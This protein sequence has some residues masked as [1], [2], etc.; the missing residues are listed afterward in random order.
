MFTVTIQNINDILRDYRIT[1][2]CIKIVELQRYYYEKDNLESKEVRLIVKAVLD[3][4]KELVIRFKN[5]QDVTFDLIE[6]Q[7][8]FAK[9]L[10]EN[11]I[12]TPAIYTSEGH[13]ARIYDF[14]GYEV[15]VTVEDFVNGELKE[16]DTDIAR[17]AGELLARMHNISE[18]ADYHISN[19]ILFDPL[20]QNEL[21]S[22][23]TFIENEC[24][25]RTID[26]DL[27]E[28]ILR[29]LN[30][31][32]Q[33]VKLFENA[34]RYAVQGDMSDCNLFKP[35]D[36]SI[37]VFD[38]NRSGDNVLY[39]DAIMQAVFVARLMN[40]PEE[41]KGKQEQVILS[42]FL[43]GYNRERPFSEK[44]KEVYPSFYALITAFDSG[45]II[46]DEKSLLNMI[47]ANDVLAVHKHMKDIYQKIHTLPV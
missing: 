32:L 8:H 38:F 25:L 27:Y 33:A 2:I 31:C 22:F 46:W 26:E 16:I 29:E 41:L 34:P 11:C 12:S 15:I 45:D 18:Q 21:F 9:L 13:F 23:E 19:E 30:S 7:S 40:Y 39:Y 1:G 37:G 28:K 44:Q 4:G 3:N 42:A 14:S 43:D 24:Y 20:I 36:G 5:E 17:K 47:K 6:S 35:Q 10:V